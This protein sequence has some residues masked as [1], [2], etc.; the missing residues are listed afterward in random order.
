MSL[1]TTSDLKQVLQ[2]VGQ[3]SGYTLQEIYISH[4]FMNR[5][6]EGFIDTRIFPQLITL[7]LRNNHIY[8]FNPNAFQGIFYFFSS[9]INKK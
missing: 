2:L 7:H 6:P 8:D 3:G 1:I 4:I 9:S 5:L